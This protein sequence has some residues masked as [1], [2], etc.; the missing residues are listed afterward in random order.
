MIVFRTC[1][2]SFSRVYMRVSVGVYSRSRTSGLRRPVRIYRKRYPRPGICQ[3]G[4]SAFLLYVG[5]DGA[6]REGKDLSGK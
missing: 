3:N 5:E 4:D 6:E 2:C 1:A